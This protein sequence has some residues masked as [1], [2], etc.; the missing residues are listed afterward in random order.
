MGSRQRYSLVKKRCLS[1]FLPLRYDNQ[2]PIDSDVVQEPSR[3]TPEQ[4]PK[5]VTSRG[6]GR[7]ARFIR[8]CH[9]R[10]ANQIGGKK[11]RASSVSSAAKFQ[12]INYYLSS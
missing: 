3:S 2:N 6:L 10:N 7:V 8:R 9:S 11:K 1:E 12:Q 4:P 5:K